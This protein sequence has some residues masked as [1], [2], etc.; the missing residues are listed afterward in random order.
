M[1]AFI[2]GNKNFYIENINRVGDNIGKIRFLYN[3]YS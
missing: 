3:D 1:F 2:V